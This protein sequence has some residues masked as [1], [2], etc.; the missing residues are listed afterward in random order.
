[1]KEDSILC[2]HC[3]TSASTSHK[4]ENERIQKRIEGGEAE[5]FYNLGIR[6]G[7]GTHGYPQDYFKALD[8]YQ[9]AADLGCAAG[10]YE[11]GVAYHN[12]VD[13]QL[14]GHHASP[15]AKGVKVDYNMAKHYYEQAAIK[16]SVIARY[17]LGF[18]WE[19]MNNIDLAIK[20]YMVAVKSGHKS[21]LDRVQVLYKGRQ[22][23][24]DVYE[25]ALNHY[26]EY[27]K[28]INE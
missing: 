15:F 25:Q 1:M 3:R 18:G 26:Q 7:R 28:K 6:Y 16:G 2:P 21:S 14:F 20:H 10:Y 24:K 9:R 19:R 22:I 13:A 11:I 5:A 4:E 12:G 17:R 27:L 23:L 8:H